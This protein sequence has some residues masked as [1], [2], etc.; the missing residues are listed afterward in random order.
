MEATPEANPCQYVL[1]QEELH[2]GPLGTNE[3][4]Y[5]KAKILRQMLE[6]IFEECYI[7]PHHIGKTHCLSRDRVIQ[8]LTVTPTDRAKFQQ[9]SCEGHWDG[10]RQIIVKHSENSVLV[11]I[12]EL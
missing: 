11:K 9:L 12:L 7:V 6:D 10:F 5:R 4:H 8:C 2:S 3:I 1:R